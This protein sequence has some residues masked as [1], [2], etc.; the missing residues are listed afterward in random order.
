MLLISS[1]HLRLHPFCFSTHF[2]PQHLQLEPAHIIWTPANQRWASIFHHL[3]ALDH[4][5][6]LSFNHMGTLKVTEMSL[7]IYLFLDSKHAGALV[8]PE[9]FNRSLH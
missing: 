5:M 2:F 7:F 6:D 8:R 4:N 9:I 1:H 3:T